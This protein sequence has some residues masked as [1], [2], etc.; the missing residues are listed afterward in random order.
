MLQAL[1]GTGISAQR[2]KRPA[3]STW[4]VICD[5]DDP[6]QRLVHLVSSRCIGGDLN[7]L[8]RYLVVELTIEDCGE[9]STLCHWDLPLQV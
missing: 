3:C 9:F 2:P 1:K 7:Y 8:A 5:V 4:I 6:H